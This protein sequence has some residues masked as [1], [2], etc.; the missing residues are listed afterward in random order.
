MNIGVFTDPNCTDSEPWTLWLLGL[1]RARFGASSNGEGLAEAEL[2][3]QELQLI[4]GDDC[5]LG[6]ATLM[7]LN[8]VRSWARGRFFSAL[9]AF[10]VLHDQFLRGL[11]PGFLESSAWPLL[12][13]DVREW[14]DRMLYQIRRFREHVALRLA[15]SLDSFRE[16]D[17]EDAIERENLGGFASHVW[18]QRLRQRERRLN[19]HSAAR[20]VL[21][22]ATLGVGSTEYMPKWEMSAA[23]S[24]LPSLQ[25]TRL[26]FRIYVYDEE[27][28]GVGELT[29]APA[30]CHFQQWG[31]DV[32]FHDFF[33]ASPLRTF[34]PEEADFFFVPTYACCH[35]LAGLMDFAD[36][37]KA[38]A[39][40]TR[41][42]PHLARAGGR[43]HVFSFHYVDLF[44]SWRQHI[45]HSVFLT[46]ET[47]VGFERSRDDFDMDPSRFPP[48]NPAKDLSVP[49]YINMADVLTL[50]HAARAVGDREHLACFAGKL[51]TDIS[52]AVD[53]RGRVAALDGLPGIAIH[54]YATVAERLDNQGMA[55]LMGASRFCFVPRGRAA[56]SVRFFETLWAGCVPVLL[57]DH[58]EPPF[59]QLFD[60]RE[61]AIKWPVDRIDESLVSFLASLPLEVVE[62]YVAAARRVRCWYLFPPPEVSWLGNWEAR[63]E[64]E[65]VEKEICPNLSSSR[66]AYQAVAEILG[67]RTR[68]TRAR[69]GSFYMPD[70]SRDHLPSV[71]DSD[72]V[73][74]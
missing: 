13:L 23:V 55:Q 37:D 4:P 27:V 10:S 44:P 28:P 18:E 21:A 48:F 47:E 62:R 34:D 25:G 38:H 59:E 43:D 1:S 9:Q 73:P 41:H 49:P 11:H 66:N 24:L 31:M 3:A 56:W 6:S 72:L 64:L 58:Y 26:P 63:A 70:P 22:G 71:T 8:V 14:R 17:I 54:A 74:L 29:R 30:F 40:L 53:V 35:Q 2:L 57:S 19:V 60:V 51:W 39:E 45:A 61:F 50:H 68:A 7:F 52:E 46:P 65:A 20:G 5:F 32:G 42:L 67:R 16:M 33:R 12:D 36:L 69:S 15:G